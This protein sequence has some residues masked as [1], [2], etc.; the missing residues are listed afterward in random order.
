VA[1]LLF[2]RDK[3]NA[4]WFSSSR[5]ALLAGFTTLIVVIALAGV[6]A[7]TA[8]AE[9]GTTA[10]A[11][12]LDEQPGGAGSIA[13]QVFDSET[14]DPLEAVKVI[15]SWPDPGGGAK[16]RQE[17]RIT[18]SDGAY[19]FAAVPPGIYDIDF[20]KSGYRASTMTNFT[21]QPDQL[22]RADFPLPPL[23]AE[24]SDEILEL[25]AFVVEAATVEEMMPNLELRMDS[26]ALLNTMS[27]ADFSKFAAGDVASALK[28]VAGVTVVKGQFAVIRGLED[29]YNSTLY[30][31]APVP[32]PDPDRQSVQLD[33]FPSEIVDNLVVAK[34]FAPDLPS[35]SSGGA[36]NII[37][38]DYPEEF[39]LELKTGTGYNENARDRF[40]EFESG[41]PVGR[42]KDG[43]DTLESDLGVSLGGRRMFAGRE[44]RFKALWSREIDYVTGEGWQQGRE[45][46][47]RFAE[48]PAGDLAAGNLSLT[49]G[50]FDFTQSARVEQ[51][52]G[53][54]GFGFDLDR[55]GNHRIDTSLFYTQKEEETVQ[56]KENG[57]FPGFDYERLREKWDRGEGIFRFDF[58]GS[59]PGS[60][61]V[62]TP[63]AWIARSVRE[64]R[65]DDPS[66]GALWFTNFSESKSFDVDR[67]LT[68]YQINGDHEIEAVDG[69]HFTWAANYATTTQEEEALGARFF[70]E[71][72]GFTSLKSLK[73]PDGVGQ[74]ELPTT[75]PVLADEL[76]Y[77][78]YVANG[79][80]FANNND[81]DEEQAFGRFDLE[82]EVNLAEGLTMKLTGGGWSEHATRD[83]ES[84]FLETAR[85]DPDCEDC[86]GR[87]TQFGVYGDTP[88]DLGRT[89]FS[90]GLA[91]VDGELSGLRK[92]ENDST[93]D[94]NGWNLGSKLTFGEELDIMG[95]FRQENIYIESKNDP[96]QFNR[97][98]TEA[99]A[100]DGSPLVFPSKWLLF[101][102]FDN[103]GRLEP[104]RDPPYNDEILGLSVPL[105]ECR[106]DARD[107]DGN[108]VPGELVPG[109][110]G[111]Q[112]VDLRSG[113]D[114]RS[115]VNGE[116]DED[117]FLPSLGIAY[118]PIEG[119]SLRGAWSQ[120]VARPSFREMGFY[121][122]VEP[123]SDDLIVG[124]PQLIL[125]DVES[126]DAR[127]EYTWGAFGDLLAVSGFT[128]TI[129]DP[130]ESIIIRDPKQSTGDS[131]LFRTFFNNPNE[132]ELWGIEIEGRKNLGF[133]GPELAEYFTVGGNWTYIDAEVDR[134]EAELARS[135]VYF[136]EGGSI[137]EDRRLFGQP[138]WI[139][140]ANLTFD[141]PDWGTKA[142]L[143]YFSIS[144]I[145]DAAGSATVGPDGSVR[146]FT[147]DRYTDSFHQLD[148]IL[149]QT[150]RI[151]LLGGGDLTFKA[152]IKNLTDSKREVI[153]DPA[154]VSG[155]IAERSYKIGR[156]YSFS[157]TYKLSF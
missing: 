102:R 57:F 95:G 114:I 11:A 97:N 149:S 82:Y 9:G 86:S 27:A 29:R 131:A 6:S 94:I 10:G 1:C 119:L 76:G 54:L 142:T 21:V 18:D 34:T 15:V 28:R 33:L 132:A 93:R 126:W 16:P 19:G 137:E 128:K 69:L 129:E 44:S 26:E 127:I 89:I 155:E 68:V 134:T 154:E 36:I 38:D 118:R 144:D 58:D 73:C 85:V 17:V 141:Q 59:L 42:E 52:T 45:P 56:L 64:E 143:A 67:D 32:S 157:L 50:R 79:R 53:Y 91:K 78:A 84:S 139:F 92:T 23:P 80:L 152:S 105:G 107:A 123:A 63:G 71:P 145:L 41:S 31:S 74:T 140:N 121:V 12:T 75:F 5:G 30:N 7:E 111:S 65:N 87:G 37:T 99:T 146:S 81:I 100:F 2:D 109:L 90:E 72:C 147:L 153:Y 35:N 156:D 96:F 110:E 136:E 115:Q 113:N 47:N 133:L 25:D 55:G 49:D 66:N 120:T 104:R 46:R 125:S 138:K 130:I 83:V 14:G 103:Y 48:P 13:G 24:M 101:D 112:C 61:G 77:G 151:G 124:N 108:L 22:N 122:S 60:T 20:V 4:D 135:E 116:I 43:S 150:W 70:F 62:A 106:Y 51:Q 117:K 40:L 39:E 148:L 8:R 3:M 98:G 88:Q